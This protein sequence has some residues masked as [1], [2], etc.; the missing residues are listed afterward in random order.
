MSMDSLQGKIR[1]T[2]SPF[3]VDLTVFP[4]ELPPHLSR[5]GEGPAAAYGT[6]CRGLMESLKGQAAAVRFSYGYC[7]MLGQGGLELLAALTKEASSL[8]YYVLVDGP[9]IN[10]PAMA[11]YTA[12]RFWG[13]APLCSCD[14]LVL[15]AYGGSDLWKPFLPFCKEKKKDL[16]VQVRTGNKSASELQDLLAG[17][18]QVHAAAADYVNRYCADTVGRSGYSN[19]A[20]AAAASS[21]DSLRALRSKYPKLFLLVDGLEYSGASVKNCASAFDQ[22]GHGAM[23]VLGSSVTCAWKKEDMA[24]G[25]YASQAA[26]ALERIRKNLGRYISVL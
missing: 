17:S 22:L 6:F 12:E 24:A 7:A 14:G 5:E 2:K 3:A 8:G 23:A 13:D 20:L 25:E 16:F 4:E 18:R 26:A 1:K 9:E 10:S 15:S 21:A 11:A 19:L